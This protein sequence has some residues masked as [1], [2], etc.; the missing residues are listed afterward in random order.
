ML[1]AEGIEGPGQDHGLD[2]PPGIPEDL[3]AHTIAAVAAIT[4][5][6][7][8]GLGEGLPALQDARDEGIAGHGAFRG[9]QGRYDQQGVA[10]D[11]VEPV[12]ALGQAEAPLD[13]P[14]G[15][16][17]ELANGRGILTAV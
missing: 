3:P 6:H 17:V 14:A 4:A 2:P 12:L 9:R 13:E 10:I 1:G 5:E 8:P 15:L 16:G 11:P 7:L